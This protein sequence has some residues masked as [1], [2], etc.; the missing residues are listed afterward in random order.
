MRTP[1][2]IDAVGARH[3]RVTSAPRIVSLVPSITELLCDLDLT[4]NLVGRTGFCVHPRDAVRGIPKLGG[5]KDVDLATLHELAPTHVILN[6]DENKSTTADAMREFVPHLVVTHPM[7]PHDNLALFKLLGGIF[8]REDRAL[9]LCDRFDAELRS[10]AP[11]Q[12]RP[13]RRV[14]YLIWRDPWMT[15][16]PDTYISRMLALVN[17]HTLP[18]DCDTRYPEIDLGSLSESPELVL[19]SS[20][21]YPFRA[22][23]IREIQAEL[24][25]AMPVTLIE[26]DQVSWYGSRAIGGLRYLDRFARETTPMM[27][28]RK[29]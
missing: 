14:L 12:S 29:Q 5:T 9:T 10:L 17:W 4:D 28:T 23:H 7:G 24:G 20:E 25:D 8:A 13:A 19:L 2:L 18:R 11:P 26:G 1:E 15:V 3:G 16:S 22:K 27:K 21:P 6:I